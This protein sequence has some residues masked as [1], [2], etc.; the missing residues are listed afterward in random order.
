MGK[1]KKWWIWMI[2]LIGVVAISLGYLSTVNIPL[3][4]PRGFIADKEFRLLITV[5]LIMCIVVV[6]VFILLAYIVWKYRDTNHTQ[7][8]Y[9]PDVASNRYLEGLWWMIPTIII[10]VLSVITWKATYALNPYNPIASPNQAIPVQVI[11]LDWK[12]LFIYPTLNVASV[13]KVVFP[14]STPVHFYLTSDAPMNSFWVPQLSGQIYNMPGMQTQLYLMAD[15]KGNYNGWSAN[16]SGI[17]FA[18]M[19][20]TAEATSHHQFVSW[21]KQIRRTAPH[22]TQAAYDQLTKPSSYVKP[23]YFSDPKTNLFNDQIMKYMMP[24]GSTM[25]GMKM[26]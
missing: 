23:K 12:W 15:Q 22:L 16:I 5:T 25:S 17:G 7:K 20:F 24:S 1:H 6:P 2:M 4:Q 26:S 19:M 11:A 9:T 8:K 3:L 13:N 14:V 18:S 21:V 10:I